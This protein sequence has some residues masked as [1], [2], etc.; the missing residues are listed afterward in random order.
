[1]FLTVL[2]TGGVTPAPGASKAERPVLT[3][4]LRSFWPQF[5][6]TAVLGLAHLYVMYIGPSLVDRFVKFVRRGGEVT[7]R[8]QLVAVLLFGN[9][10]EGLASHHYEF[11]RQKLGMRINAALLA[12][13]YLKSL[14]L[15]TGVRRAHGTGTI[16]NYMEVD[17]QEVADVTHQL[18]NLWLMPLQI[19]VAL[20]LLYTHLGPAVLT[21]VTAI[22]VV[23][24]V[25]S[26]ANKLNIE[27]Q[28]K[29]LGKRDERMKA[30]TELLNYIRV[31]KLQAWEELC[32]LDTRVLI[33]LP[34]RIPRIRTRVDVTLGRRRL[35]VRSASFGRKSWDG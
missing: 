21:A 25:V 31:I 27:Y 35:G 19:A 16:V 34:S 32:Y 7:E 11:Q 23:T 28:F 13:M 12:A 30:I 22:A 9:A 26:F 4:L 14:R 2:N 6:L 15:S 10:A 5:L 17:A 20:A 1:M 18:H 3:A 29:F 33:F 24:V 8:L